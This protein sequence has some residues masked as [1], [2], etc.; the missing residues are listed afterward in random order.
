MMEH[1]RFDVS[2]TFEDILPNKA[3]I[4]S[5]IDETKKEY[6]TYIQELE[7]RIELFED[8]TDEISLSAVEALKEE[9][10]E[11]K[12]EFKDY[13]NEIE[14]YIRPLDEDLTVTIQDDQTNQTHTVTIPTDALSSGGEAAKGEEGPIGG[15]PG[16]QPGVEN[17]KD[18]PASQI[19][20]GDETELLSDEPSIE[21]DSVDMGADELEAEADE[22]EAE[23][24]ANK[25]EGAVE[26]GAEG[27]PVEPGAEGA[28]VEPGAE[29]APVEPVEDE[30][31][32]TTPEEEEEEDKEKEL[33]DSVETPNLERSSFDQE[34][35]QEDNKTK[36]R[37]FLKR[38]I[39][40]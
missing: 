27:A 32:L 13:N 1:L 7:S 22:K 24:E 36:K 11:I 9:L 26:P 18:G 5:Q 31:T 37:V 4:L 3:K 21:S 35:Q 34:K 19:T 15:E 23:A 33:N 10:N 14:R 30:T 28:P 29:G 2:K 38:K 25:E 12:N 39:A 20:F 6:I 17:I 16:T 40:K 8:N